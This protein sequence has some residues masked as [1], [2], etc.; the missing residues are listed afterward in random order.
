MALTIRLEAPADYSAIRDVVTAAFGRAVEADLVDRLR[1]EGDSVISL[2]AVESGRIVGHV[3]FSRMI[4]PF[5]ALGM[6]PVSVVPDRQRSGIGSRLIRAGLDRAA[7]DEW[8]GIFVL[9]EPTFYRR[10]GFDP[11]LARGFNSPYAGPYLMA[12]ALGGAMPAAE[13]RIEYAPAFAGLT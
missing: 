11:A 3:L 10:F 4:A 12:L 8:Q 13:G 5:R 2:V 6:A 7:Q 9:G 1:A